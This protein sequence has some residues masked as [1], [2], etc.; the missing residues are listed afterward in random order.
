MVNFKFVNFYD[1]SLKFDE[2]NKILNN[3]FKSVFGE[4][5]KNKFGVYKIKL[6]SENNIIEVNSIKK[7]GLNESKMLAL[8]KKN[9]KIDY[10]FDENLNSEYLLFLNF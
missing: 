3:E 6:D 7:F 8:I 1:N 2:A 4:K 5:L 10:L 9:I